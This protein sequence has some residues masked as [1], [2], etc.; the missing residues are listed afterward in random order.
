MADY[1]PQSNS[2][3][4]EWQ[5]NL[6]NET[7]NNYVSW[8]IPKNSFTLL[9]ESQDPW[10]LAF[11]VASNKHNRTS[12]DIQAR[13]DAGKSYK[14]EIRIFVAQWLSK[15]TSVSDSER[16]IL[17]ITIPN[18]KHV[19]SAVPATS[20]MGTV[21]F[22]I[23]EQHTIRYTDMSTSHRKAKPKGVYGCEIWLKK[24]NETT[25]N[26]DEFTFLAVCTRSPYKVTFELQDVGKTAWYYLR[27][28]NTRGIHGPWSNLI[29]GIIAG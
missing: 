25:G 28:I 9:K 2:K 16:M 6:V 24:G 18:V 10:A 26:I 3:F 27:W 17:G 29:S 20:P 13:N 19:R 15:N 7:E 23:R 5:A 4:N 11:S 21:D 22:S 12:A 8:G 1:I 14:K